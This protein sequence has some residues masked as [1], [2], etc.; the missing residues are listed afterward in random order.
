MRNYFNTD[1]LIAVDRS[2]LHL[3]NIQSVKYFPNLLL[4]ATL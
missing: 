3:E 1:I 4:K 2:R